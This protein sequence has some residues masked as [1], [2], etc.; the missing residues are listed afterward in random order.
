MTYKAKYQYFTIAARLLFFK[1][2]T[3]PKVVIIIIL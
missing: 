1:E 2:N 3:I